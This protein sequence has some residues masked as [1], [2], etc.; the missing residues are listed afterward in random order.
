MD[1][2]DLSV[3]TI[4]IVIVINRWSENKKLRYEHHNENFKESILCD[5]TPFELQIKKN[6]GT[7]VILS[8]FMNRWNSA[9]QVAEM[10]L[11]ELLWE[12]TEI[13]VG[14]LDPAFEN[15]LKEAFSGNFQ[16]GRAHVI[17]RDE[18]R[19]KEQMN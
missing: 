3:I 9:L 12:E 1:K 16:A 17:K 6:P 14:S 8:D 11:M 7:N 4:Y 10:N 19:N 2:G 5:I 15:S 13:V 18:A